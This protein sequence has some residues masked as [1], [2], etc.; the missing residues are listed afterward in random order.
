MLQNNEKHEIKRETRWIV[1]VKIYSEMQNPT[2]I[3]KKQLVNKILKLINGL[4]LYE[5]GFPEVVVKNRVRQTL[6]N[7]EYFSVHCFEGFLVIHKGN[8]IV[9]RED[10][11]CTVENVILK[12]APDQLYK[13]IYH[14]I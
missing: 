12:S 9:I 5:N 10:I 13:N 2:W 7:S 1:E 8:L 11:E 14:Y 6:T 4:P 3:I